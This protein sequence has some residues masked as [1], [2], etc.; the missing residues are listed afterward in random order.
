MPSDH[1]DIGTVTSGRSG[2]QYTVTWYPISGEIYVNYAGGS[3][4]G[5]AS[6]PRDAMRKAEAWLYNK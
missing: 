2:S 6:S 4:V 3:Y 5:K 1:Q